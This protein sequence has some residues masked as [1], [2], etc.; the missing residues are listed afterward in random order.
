MLAALGLT[1]TVTIS[2][3]S[4]GAR[5]EESSRDSAFT[6]PFRLVDHR[7]FVEVEVNGRGPFQFILDTGSDELLSDSTARRLGLTVRSAGVGEGVGAATQQFGTTQVAELRLGALRLADVTCSVT[8]L[9]DT[10]QVFGTQPVDGVIGKGVFERM[11]V[12]LDY[13]HRVLTFTPPGEY[14]APASGTV[15]TIRRPQQIP[16]VEATLDGVAGRFGVDTGARSA[17]LLYGPFCQ[18]NQLAVKYGA[19][20][21]GVTGWGIGGPVRSLIARAHQL[22]IGGVSVRDPIVRLST[23]KT[24]LTTSSDMAGLIGPDVLWQFDVTFDYARMRMILEKSANYG[25]PDSYDRLGVWM[26]QSGP[27]FWAVDVIAG[28]PGDQAGVRTGDT[29]LAIDGRRTDT[30]SLPDVREEMRRR[31]VGEKVSLLVESHGR[32]HTVVVML[33]DLA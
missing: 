14:R 10:P 31:R 3:A 8:S 21:Q 16:V 27:H 2:L 18:Q 1:G 9:G 19:R 23:Q 24:G 13:V 30:L 11:V 28:G 7:V 25:R 22:D 29:I 15:L 32:R 20:W 26:G 5:A 12:K 6:M 4:V 17:L 33:R